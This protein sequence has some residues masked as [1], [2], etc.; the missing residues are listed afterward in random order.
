MKTI[1]LLLATMVAILTLTACNTIEG[2]GEDVEATGDA[3]SDAAN[4]AK[5]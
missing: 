1:A 5:P 3:V 2:V 4:A